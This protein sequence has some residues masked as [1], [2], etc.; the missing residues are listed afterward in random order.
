MNKAPLHD[1]AVIIQDGKIAATLVSGTAG[2]EDG[3]FINSPTN[4][5]NTAYGMGFKFSGLTATDEVTGCT[6]D[7]TTY[8][9]AANNAIDSSLYNSKKVTL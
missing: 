2:R 6:M 4:G 8:V 7:T 9:A 3:D 1:G 5:A